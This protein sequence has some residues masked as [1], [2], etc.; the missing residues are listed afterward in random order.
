MMH[1]NK[2]ILEGGMLSYSLP[3]EIN[4]Y[5]GPIMERVG[6]ECL[7]IGIHIGQKDGRGVGIRFNQ[8]MFNHLH[9]WVKVEE[10]EIDL[11]KSSCI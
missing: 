4:F 5:G 1:R 2:V 10:E 11:S 7:A 8:K 6:G 3:F 9:D